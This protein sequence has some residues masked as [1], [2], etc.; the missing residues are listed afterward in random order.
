MPELPN[1]LDGLSESIEVIDKQI[2]ELLAQRAE[3]TTKVG[4]YKSKSGS[5]IYVAEA[6]ASIIT[7]RKSEAKRQGVSPV[8]IEDLMRRI[9]RESY[10]TK[11]TEF[12]CTNPDI[13]KIVVV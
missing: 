12:L 5:P 7:S 4:E 1:E 3:L 11:S 8:L 10:H 13:K 9:M 6:E 2:V